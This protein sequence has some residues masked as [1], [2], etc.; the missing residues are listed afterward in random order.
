MLVEL[1][2]TVDGELFINPNQVS[3]V[4]RYGAESSKIFFYDGSDVMV[5]GTT[6]EVA[7]KLDTDTM[8]NDPAGK[9]GRIYAEGFRNGMAN[10]LTKS[11]HA[12]RTTENTCWQNGFDA[13]REHKRKKS[14]ET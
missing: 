8:R 12:E 7:A 4:C 1:E 5:K 2:P 6:Q 10:D 13:G 14:R 3:R 11:P 9:A